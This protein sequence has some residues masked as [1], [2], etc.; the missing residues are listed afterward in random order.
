MMNYTH[1][2]LTA[3]PFERFLFAILFVGIAVTFTRGV[4][5]MV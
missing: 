3:A 2:M 4:L 5:F 1:D